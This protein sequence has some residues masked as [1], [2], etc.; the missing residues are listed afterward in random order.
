MGL[1]ARDRFSHRG[2]NRSDR[3]KFWIFETVRPGTWLRTGRARRF[4]L[5]C[6]LWQII[7]WLSTE[8]RRILKTHLNSTE[9]YVQMHQWHLPISERKRG[10]TWE[11]YITIAVTRQPWRGPTT[12]ISW[13]VCPRASCP[14]ISNIHPQ[15][16]FYFISVSF[17][18]ALIHIYFFYN[19]V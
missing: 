3:K 8:L 12:K 6:Q 5:L 17:S 9:Q 19:L 18:F 7:G 16:K 11:P 10:V 15:Y 13:H 14:W 4:Y 1:C 2:W